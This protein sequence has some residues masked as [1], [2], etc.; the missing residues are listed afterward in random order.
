[1][2]QFASVVGRLSE[3]MDK[4]AGFCIFGV[5]LLVVGNVLLRA[6]FKRPILGTY[7]MVGYLT[8][9]GIS[10]SLAHC[11][12]QKGHIALDFITEKFPEVMRTVNQ[13]I[14]HSIA[15]GFW[16]LSALYISKYAKN[17]MASDVVS[18]TAQIPVYPF[19]ML[20]GFGLLCLCLVSLVG[21]VE[22]AGKVFVN[23]TA[24]RAFSRPEILKC[25]RKASR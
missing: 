1:M 2:K 7:E 15:L 21:L 19:V 5:M 16:G 8:A 20:V 9:L 23:I 13:A 6:V 25:M 18:P 3:D 24:V 11:A 10:F 12:L 4:I 17:M 14:I 22:S